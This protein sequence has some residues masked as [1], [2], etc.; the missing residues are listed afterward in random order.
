MRRLGPQPGLR[1]PL[2]MRPPVEEEP[3][4]RS[5]CGE[6]DEQEWSCVS[7][8]ASYATRSESSNRGGSPGNIQASAGAH[9]TL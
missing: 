6:G 5:V 3:K 7:M 9:P 8:Q 2:R 4:G 1:R